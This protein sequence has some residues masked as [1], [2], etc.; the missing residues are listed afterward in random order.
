MTQNDQKEGRGG[1]VSDAMNVVCQNSPLPCLILDKSRKVVAANDGICRLTLKSR[2][3]RSQDTLIG[4]ALGEL[5]FVALPTQSSKYQ[6]FKTLLDDY[7]LDPQPAMQV[8]HAKYRDH[9][10][11]TDFWDQE[12]QAACASLEVVVS[13]GRANRGQ[14]QPLKL[15]QIRARMSLLHLRLGSDVTYMI[16]FDR[17]RP[18]QSSP[19][20]QAT[21]GKLG[22]SEA[23]VNE[24]ELSKLPARE[25]NGSANKAIPYTTATFDV[26]GR[27]LE[28]SRAWYEFFETT[29]HDSLGT[30]WFNVI[31]PEDIEPLVAART[32][33][34]KNDEDTWSQEVRYRTKDDSYRWSIIRA[35][36]SRDESGTITSWYAS[37]M[38]IDR[39][40]RSSQE[41]GNWRESI[42]T[43]AANANICLWGLRANRTLF[44][45]EGS[46]SWDPTIV[47]D[48][49]SENETTARH[50]GDKSQDSLP[51]DSIEG[52][53][54]AVSEGRL[55]ALRLEH[56]DSGRWYQSTLVADD[57][58]PAKRG[59]GQGRQVLGLTT[60]IT[61]VRARAK[62][63]AENASLI[64]KE[65]V[66]KEASESKSKFL[67]NVSCP[68]PLNIRLAN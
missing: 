29:E 54:K 51:I 28:I 32:N 60:D 1:I 67:A 44:L 64:M 27:A 48:S 4:K 53:I 36:S 62:L 9:E 30:K 34:I 23:I 12:E 63:E 66:A 45:K 3:V 15:T 55:A 68:C 58:D 2:E 16:S 43:L 10:N 57:C 38:D 40:L 19:V 52:A 46:M 26:D 31:H 49:Q 42:M 41:A 59:S 25:V 7:P 14:M 24:H 20:P 22:S 18:A 8:P 35:A 61:D 17:P 39:L 56:T 33:A 13:R 37:M 47:F 65:K 5:G 6:D 11:E 21:S 50:S